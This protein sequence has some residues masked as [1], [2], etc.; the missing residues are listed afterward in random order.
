MMPLSCSATTKTLD[1]GFQSFAGAADE[2]TLFL[3]RLDDGE[4]A[5]DV[6]DRRIRRLASGAA[7]I[8]LPTPS[9]CE[10]FEE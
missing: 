9:A 2:N 6:V 5:A 10:Q 8:I 4:D 3:E 7:A 1:L